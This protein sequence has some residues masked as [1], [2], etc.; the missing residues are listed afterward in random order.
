MRK[1]G[2]DLT[3]RTKAGSM[4]NRNA[5]IS[6]ASTSRRYVLATLRLGFGA[7]T[8]VSILATLLETASRATINPFN[9]FGYFTI[10]S[11]ALLAIVAVTAGV[12]G[13]IRPGVQPHWLVVLR[14]LATVC[15][16]IV[17]LVYA[18][19]L[20]PLGLEGGVPVPWANWVMHVAGPILVAA[21]WLFARDR[22]ALPWRVV[23]VLL[24]YPVGWTLVVLIRGATDGWVPYPFLD[25][26]QGY[27]VVAVYVV[28][29]ALVFTIVSTAVVWWSRRHQR[30]PA[31]Q[32]N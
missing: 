4:V 8:V 5:S 6:T 7:V 20:A 21:D 32:D 30:A 16:I 26:A 17:G 19:L 3:I 12:I 1:N 29:I 11:N 13:F 24:I 9:F 22:A 28:V 14:S 31:S 2:H 18:V 10:Q 25:P 15:M 23:P 27:G